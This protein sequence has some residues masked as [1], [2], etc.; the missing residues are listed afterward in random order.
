MRY[1]CNFERKKEQKLVKFFILLVETQLRK[2]QHSAIG[3]STRVA[4][5]Q[6]KFTTLTMTP[7]DYSVRI[8]KPKISRTRGSNLERI[9][10]S[11]F[12]K[13]SLSTHEQ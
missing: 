11:V 5:A 2:T 7:Q 9:T 8:L 6:F 1:C 3:D 10:Y 12:I 4:W 13:M